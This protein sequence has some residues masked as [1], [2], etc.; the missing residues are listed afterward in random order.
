MSPLPIKIIFNKICFDNDKTFYSIQND[1]SNY[2]IKALKDTEFFPKIV[3]T[4]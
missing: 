2:I 4:L 1:L 3:Y